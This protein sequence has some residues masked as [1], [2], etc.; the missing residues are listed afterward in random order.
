MKLPLE[1]MSLA[2]VA[3]RNHSFKMHHLKNYDE[4]VTKSYIMLTRW[5]PENEEDKLPIFASHTIGAGGLV[6]SACRTRFLAIQERVQRQ[7]KYGPNW[8]LPGGLLNQSGESIKDGVEREVWEETGVKATFQ[9]TFGFRE[10]VSWGMFQQPDLYMVCLLQLQKEQG[11]HIDIQHV[12]EVSKAAW[13]D[14]KA[15]PS[16]Q[17]SPIATSFLRDLHE[18]YCREGNLDKLESRVL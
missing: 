5:L 16:H 4:D 17:F 2:D 13:I 9:G 8:K 6:L 15:I 11:E 12:S 10:L 14:V 7:M 3:I 18:E 1:K